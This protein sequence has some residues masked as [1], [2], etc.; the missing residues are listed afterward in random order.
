[1]ERNYYNAE[2]IEKIGYC[3]YCPNSTKLNQTHYQEIKCKY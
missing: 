2:S 3:E 1:M